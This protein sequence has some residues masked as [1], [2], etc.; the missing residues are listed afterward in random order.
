MLAI[1]YSVPVHQVIV[2]CYVEIHKREHHKYVQNERNSST[3]H[4]FHVNMSANLY[5]NLKWQL[6]IM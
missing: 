3:P 2:I 4:Q 5:Q 1:I 6:V